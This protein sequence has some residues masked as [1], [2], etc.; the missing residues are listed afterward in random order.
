MSLTRID[1]KTA[2]HQITVP[3]ADDMDDATFEAHMNH[4]HQS[5]LGGIPS[6]SLS[7]AAPSLAR[8]WRAFHRR[9]HKL[10]VPGQYEHKHLPGLGGTN[11]PEAGE[12]GPMPITRPKP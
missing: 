3:S 2:M 9:L 1:M 5:S 6:I 4:R 8:A 12:T 7:G 11:Y 10:E